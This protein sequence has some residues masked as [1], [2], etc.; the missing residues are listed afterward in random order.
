[1]LDTPTLVVHG[2]WLLSSFYCCGAV[3]FI[4]EEPFV[5]FLVD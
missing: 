3:L 2:L 4:L 5:T 1:M